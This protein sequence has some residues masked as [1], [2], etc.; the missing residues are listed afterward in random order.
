MVTPIWEW[1][2]LNVVCRVVAWLFWFI[3]MA[4]LAVIRA[5]RHMFVMD[6]DTAGQYIQ[7]WVDSPKTFYDY[8]VDDG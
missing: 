7:A 3:V 4:P 5:Y 8:S 6:I 2:V 1:R